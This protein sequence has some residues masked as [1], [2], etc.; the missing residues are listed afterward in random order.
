MDPRDN[1]RRTPLF[2]AAERG[3]K[4]TVKLLL[5]SGADV[6]AKDMDYRS[7]VRVAVGHAAT[8]EVLLQVRAKYQH[9]NT[10]LVTY[11]KLHK[12]P[13]FFSRVTTGL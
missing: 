5:D 6:T 3:G 2:L 10:S 4:D 7:C 11:N 9:I 12:T 13:C 1:L 8:M